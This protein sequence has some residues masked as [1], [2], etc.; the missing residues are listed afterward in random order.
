MVIMVRNYT[1]LHIYFEQN[2]SATAFFCYFCHHI[3]NVHYFTTTYKFTMKFNKL[4]MF[5]RE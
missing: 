2:I 1:F 3:K 4:M 5:T